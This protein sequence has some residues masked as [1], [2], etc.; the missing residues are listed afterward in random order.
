MTS[1]SEGMSDLNGVG[2]LVQLVAS[3]G[4]RLEAVEQRMG[5]VEQRLAV[6]PEME[7]GLERLVRVQEGMCAALE[8]IEVALVG[9]AG[10]GEGA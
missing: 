3:V 1:V 2:A 9:R 7:R 10:A 6:L 4:Q 8:R 5:V